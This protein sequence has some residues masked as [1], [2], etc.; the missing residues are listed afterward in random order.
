MLKCVLRKKEL[1]GEE[2]R[3]GGVMCFEACAKEELLGMAGVP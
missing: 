2:G 3:G 1:L